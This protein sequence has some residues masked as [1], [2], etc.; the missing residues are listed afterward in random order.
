MSNPK[1][2]MLFALSS[3]KILSETRQILSKTVLLVEGMV[4][5][6][7]TAKLMADPRYFS[8]EVLIRID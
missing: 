1:G 4:S 6:T 7:D 2:M 5:A 8:D 3:L